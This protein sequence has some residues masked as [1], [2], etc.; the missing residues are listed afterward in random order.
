M[1]PTFESESP[2]SRSIFGIQSALRLR[3]RCSSCATKLAVVLVCWR[4]W[5]RPPELESGLPPRLPHVQKGWACKRRTPSRQSLPAARNRPL[6]RG[7]RTTDSAPPT[8][9]R[10]AGNARENGRLAACPH[11]LRRPSQMSGGRVDQG[12]ASC[13]G[14][15]VTD[16]LHTDA[17]GPA[18]ETFRTLRSTVTPFTAADS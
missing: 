4:P 12:A 2:P 1:S 6:L 10:K 17:P 18:G 3:A 14:A 11:R 5:G 15:V 7:N 8:D 16:D 9:K 13:G